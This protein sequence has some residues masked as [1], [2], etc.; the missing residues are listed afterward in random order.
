MRRVVYLDTS[1]LCSRSN[2]VQVLQD[3]KLRLPREPERRTRLEG[4]NRRSIDEGHVDET[5]P[6]DGSQLVLQQG[7]ILGGRGEQVAVDSRKITVDLLV[8]DDALD[9]ID[10]GRMARRGE[11]SP[12]FAV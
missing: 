1:P 8:A 11:P 10:R 6:V 2:S 9:S 4:R 5:R 7:T 12:L 3:V